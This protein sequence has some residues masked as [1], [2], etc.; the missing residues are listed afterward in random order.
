MKR[1]RKYLNLISLFKGH[2]L[3]ADSIAREMGIVLDF[4]SDLNCTVWSS[5]ILPMQYYLDKNKLHTSL[6]SNYNKLNMSHGF[7]NFG[8]VQLMEAFRCV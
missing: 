8:E 1:F 2:F 3:L 7:K 5:S 6:L 4:G